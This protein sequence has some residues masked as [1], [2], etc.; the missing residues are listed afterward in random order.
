M[1]LCKLLPPAPDSGEQDV[2]NLK[3]VSMKCTKHFV[4]STHP[5]FFIEDFNY[6]PKIL[7]IIV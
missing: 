7:N 6:I 5:F 4:L 1:Y 3:N 2:E